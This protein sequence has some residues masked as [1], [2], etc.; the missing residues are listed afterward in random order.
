MNNGGYVSK[1]ALVVVSLWGLVLALVLAAWAVAMMNPDAWSVAAVLAMT[2]CATSAL[3]ATLHIRL[4]AT[5]IC[6][7]IRA[8]SGLDGPEPSELRALP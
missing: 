1:A 4:F 8:T 5:R 6:R 2:G 7:L 3:A